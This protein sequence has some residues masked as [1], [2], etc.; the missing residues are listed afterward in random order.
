MNE[1]KTKIVVKKQHKTFS[2]CKKKI[3]NKIG[4]WNIYSWDIW[5]C[6]VM[7]VRKMAHQN[8]FPRWNCHPPKIFIMPTMLIGVNLGWKQTKHV[9]SN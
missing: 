3:E 5:S 8:I 2:M 7:K 4:I 1:K 6:N 9:V